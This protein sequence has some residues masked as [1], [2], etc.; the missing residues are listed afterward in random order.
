MQLTFLRSAVIRRLRIGVRT[1]AH[2]RVAAANGGRPGPALR[3]ALTL[4]VVLAASSHTA[5]AQ[6]DGL[7]LRQALEN[8][9]A[10]NKQLAAFQH[11]FAE[12]QGRV[13][14]AG[15]R[16]NP[17]VDLLFEN[18]GGQGDFQGF[19]NAETTLTIGWAIEPGLRER[20]IGVAEAQSARTTLDAQI[21][22]L[23]VAAETAQRFL[24]CLES[25]THLKATEEAVA[26]S[27]RTVAAVER[28]VQA[29]RAPRA[30]LMGARA[31]LAIERLARDDVTHER[32]VAYHRLAAQWGE[33][34]PSFARVGGDLLTLPVVAPFE[35]FATRINGNPELARLASEQRIAEAELRLA[36][37]RRFPTLT[38]S[39]GARRLEVT[40][41]WALVAGL[42]VPF[43]LFDRN[44][45]RVAESHAALARK[46]A[47]SEAERVRVHTKLYEIYQEM[48]HSV[49]RAEVL[50]EEVIPRRDEAM[51]ATR[52][53][54]TQGRYRY[55]ELRT[56]EADLL[57]ARRSLVEASTAAHRLVITLERLTGERVAR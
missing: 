55:Y 8:A 24:S 44:Q 27:E 9:L 26:L 50:G 23:D 7:T 57:A 19:D 56:V 30:E 5:S 33:T 12:Q 29:G 48:Q 34:A 18:L 2:S 28:R 42:R 10:Q 51:D 11:R 53:G 6:E 35:E 31:E 41:D 16:P 25:Q 46:R 20:R 38:P 37:A 45:G 22:R 54:Y 47:D 3:A 43:P 36:K 1:R 4:A 39:V 32:S 49:H 14:Q 17:Q 13:Q 15:L 40:N 21:L 52:T